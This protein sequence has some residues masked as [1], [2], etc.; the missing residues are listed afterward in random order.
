MRGRDHGS[1][2]L[3]TRTAYVSVM[4]DAGTEIRRRKLALLPQSQAPPPLADDEFIGFGVDGG[5]ACLVDAQAVLRSYP[6]RPCVVRPVPPRDQGV[7][8]RPT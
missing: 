3:D 7:V 6:K 8:G 4:L 5:K 1:P 2:V